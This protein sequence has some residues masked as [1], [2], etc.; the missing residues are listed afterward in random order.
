MKIIVNYYKKSD[1][2]LYRNGARL[3]VDENKVILKDIFRNIFEL[4]TA[5]VKFRIL[6]GQFLYSSVELFNDEVSYELLLTK[7]NERKLLEYFHSIGK[8][9]Y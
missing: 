5:D 4:N 9:E 1:K 2:H 7:R 8:F 3:L 6:P